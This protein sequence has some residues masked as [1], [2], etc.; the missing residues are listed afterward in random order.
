[1]GKR[2]SG[3]FE[4]RTGS[5]LRF[6]RSKRT[7]RGGLFGLVSLVWAGWIAGCGGDTPG[8]SAHELA[9][10]PGSAEESLAVPDEIE[11]LQGTSFQGARESGEAHLPVLYVSSSGFAE[12]D[13]S[14]GVT[15]VTAELV[16]AFGRFV[17]DAH[18][19]DVTLEFI[20]EPRWATFYERVKS[21]QGGVFGL[22]NV[23]ITETRRQELAFSPPYLNN[24][25]TLITHEGVAELGSLQEIAEAFVDL[26]GLL[27][28][29]TLHEERLEALRENHYPDMRTASVE[30]NYE[31]V[32]RVASGEGYF[33]YIDIYNFWRAVEDGHP[34][35][36]HSVADDAS[37]EFGVI[38]PRDS[39]W[40]PVMEQFFATN[41]GVQGAEWYRELLREHLGEELAGLLDG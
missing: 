22:G 4:E 11:S 26:T 6:G 38:M 41:E 3:R 14:G 17:Q 27:Y 18:G 37:E 21:S 12:D 40:V 13:G 19:I 7:A 8:S 24:V 23:T 30:T 9:S 35:R 2:G 31:L 25:A 5:D 34:L 39:D 32:G 33:G 20:E 36:R 28:P 1:M 16:K 10:S 15:G 29:G